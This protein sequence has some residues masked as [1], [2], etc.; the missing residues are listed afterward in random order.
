[1]FPFV[2]TVTSPKELVACSPPVDSL[3]GVDAGVKPTHSFPV[4]A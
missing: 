1:M 2:P 3:V 4:Y